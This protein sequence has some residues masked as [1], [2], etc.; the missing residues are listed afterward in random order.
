MENPGLY[1]LFAGEITTA[2]M[3]EAS[4]AIVDLDGMNAVSLVAKLGYG[5]GGTSIA[6]KVQTSLDGGTTWL[7]VARFD[8]TTA[9]ATKVANLSG[10]TAKSA[11]A[12]AALGS[13]G[14][15][16]GLLGDRL[17]A[18]ITSVG[19]YAGGTTLDIRAAVR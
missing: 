12:Y 11:A 17:R 2:L 6:A 4:E 13:E 5:S 14:V 16:D 18:V 9:G 7:D 15:N 3:N 19:T 8:F 1:T 10:L